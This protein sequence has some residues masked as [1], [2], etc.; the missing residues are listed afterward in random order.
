V[1]TPP[2]LPLF[3]SLLASDEGRI[4]VVLAFFRDE[5]NRYLAHV[6]VAADIQVICQRCLVDMP[7]HVACESTLAVVYSDEQAAALPRHLDPL[8]LEDEDCDLRQ[9]V[10]EELIL[11]LKPFNY[12]DTA[13]C[14]GS[15][16]T[17]SAPEEAQAPQE[18]RPNPFD[19][20][21]QLKAGE[22]NQE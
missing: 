4:E 15:I 1:L 21:V 6:V 11:A 5:E 2:D 14:R 16:A 18:E 19:V 22:N 17:F 13:A 9:L 7:E 20:L 8:V 10:E 3:R 12:H